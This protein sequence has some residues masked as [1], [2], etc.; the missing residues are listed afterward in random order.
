MTC[1]RDN[2]SCPKCC[3]YSSLYNLSSVRKDELEY[4]VSYIPLL[5]MKPSPV[6]IN[7]NFTVF[8]GT[9]SCG[10]A[11][12]PCQL[13]V[14]LLF[15]RSHQLATSCVEKRNGNCQ[16]PVHVEDADVC[17]ECDIRERLKEIP[18]IRSAP[19]LLRSGIPFHHRLIYGRVCPSY[20]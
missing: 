10:G 2:I 4:R 3:Q 14:H 19:R 8:G 13:R 15:L 20:P 12:L 7:D 6:G 11:R 5:S 1:C 17:V 16:S 9:A 18:Y